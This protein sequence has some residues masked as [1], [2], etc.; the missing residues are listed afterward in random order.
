MRQTIAAL[1]L[2]AGLA[3]GSPAHA[4]QVSYPPPMPPQAPST[5]AEASH[6][7]KA[8]PGWLPEFQ[9]NSGAV[10]VWVMLF[11]AVA[12]PGDGAVTPVKWYQ[13]PAASTLGVSFTPVAL[14][15]TTGITAVCSTTGPFTKTA[16]ATCT[17]SGEV[18]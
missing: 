18:Q 15:F 16:T 1:G 2:V 4:Q 13:L 5:A 7:F 10:S 3:L 12:A 6:V 17:F 9:V 14:Q 8:G 11:N